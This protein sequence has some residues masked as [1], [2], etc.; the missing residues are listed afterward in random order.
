M[1]CISNGV[2]VLK[3]R[4]TVDADGRGPEKGRL[5]IQTWTG[6]CLCRTFIEMLPTPWFSFYTLTPHVTR[7]SLPSGPMP[8]GK[9]PRPCVRRSSKDLR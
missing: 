7:W 4:E 9:K 3:L 5:T 2:N 8:H 6:G 1:N